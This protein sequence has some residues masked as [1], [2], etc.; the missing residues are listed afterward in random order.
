ME[1]T[2]TPLVTSDKIRA[3]DAVRGWAIFLVTVVHTAAIFVNMPWPI[4]KATNFGWYGVQLFFIASAFTLLMSWNRN[5]VRGNSIGEFFKRRFFRIAPMYYLGTLFYFLVRPPGETFDFFQL[6]Y[7]MSFI[8]SWHPDWLGVTDGFWSVVPGGWSISVEFCF[9]LIFP[10]LAIY[11]NSLNRSLLFF[12]ASLLLSFMSFDM[13]D[14]LFNSKDNNIYAFFWMPS[15]LVVFSLGFIAYYFV[16]G[17]KDAKNTW[18]PNSWFI[19]VLLVFLSIITQL[20]NTKNFFDGVKVLPTHITVSIVFCMLLI[21][22]FK[23]EKIPEFIVN[24]AICKFGEVSFSAYLIHF[25]MISILHD[26]INTSVFQVTGILS[27][28]YF[29]VLMIPVVLGT[30]F[31]SRVTYNFVEKPFINFSKNNLSFKRASL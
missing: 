10:I 8:N 26:F 27:V 3:I 29:L 17:N 14:F 22:L 13:A 11:I 23:V 4:K 24:K 31:F 6:F 5:I 9:Y 19:Y 20:G 28:L 25:F 30:Y 7:S 16:F 12:C 21:L 15:Q 2:S 1:K 18:R